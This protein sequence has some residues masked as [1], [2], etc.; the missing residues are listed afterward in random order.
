[1]TE[2]T[3]PKERALIVGVNV[4]QDPYF[5]ESIEELKNL[6]IACEIEPVAQI[7]QNLSRPHA[8]LYIG[9]G[10]L[11]EIK[12]FVDREEIDVLIFE[13]ELSPSQLRNI[14]KHLSTEILDRTRLILEIF[15]SRAQTRE[16]KAQVEI[17]K[18]RYALPRL[19][20]TNQD[21][22]RQ[23]GGTGTRNRGSG[24]TKLEL[25]RR[26]IE[27]QI[28][29]LEKELENIG[30]N[31]QV[32]RK[33]RAD[34]GVP[35]IA[36]VGYT[37]AGKSTLMN[38]MVT[39]YQQDENKLVFE[40]DML[41]ATLETSVRNI[42]FEDGRTIL[43]S[44]TVGFI[45]KLPHH[46]VKAFHSTLEEVRE[47]D[48]LLHVVDVSNPNH[49][50]HLEVTNDTLAYIEADHVPQIRVYNK[51]DLAEGVPQLNGE[52]SACV[53]AKKGQGIPQLIQVLTQQLFA[54]YKK[55]K[56]LIPYDQGQVIAYLKDNATVL[57]ISYD[58]TGTVI[59]VELSE[60]DFERYGAYV[61][62]AER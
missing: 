14:S 35:I 4:N 43:L 46:L 49:E 28:S 57:G 41:F 30:R 22:D 33:R 53:S 56:L 29:E 9:T 40:K 50:K 17:A 10:K 39:K 24:E 16:A 32:Q 2:T 5:Q 48:L 25:N 59:D 62:E 20:N 37:N 21:F 7:T 47:A 19:R 18:L 61:I 54:D 58:D 3:Q 38:A 15:A 11:D 27:I 55:C 6:A 60:A 31:R 34:S 23:R 1:M 52:S 26:K 12:D 36:L 42:K 13:D 45:N 51:V 44:D 8:A